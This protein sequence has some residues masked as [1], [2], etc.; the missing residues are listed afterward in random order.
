MRRQGLADIGP[1][2]PSRDRTGTPVA[3]SP[4]VE[5]ERPTGPPRL[6]LAGRSGQTSWREREAARQAA[7]A[8]GEAPPPATEE[9]A[10]PAPATE[11]APRPG[12]FVP[13]ALRGDRPTGGWREREGSGRSGRSGRDDSPAGGSAPRYQARRDFGDRGERGERSFSGRGRDTPEGRD[14]PA[15]AGAGKYRPRQLRGEGGRPES[16]TTVDG[17]NGAS[18]SAPTPRQSATSDG[19]YRPGAFSQRKQQQ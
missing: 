11:E 17:E 1:R 10:A 8:S 9:K 4:T 6:N 13:P 5:P 19:K 15:D 12:R 16:P 14:S 7:A 2:I 3:A 18:A